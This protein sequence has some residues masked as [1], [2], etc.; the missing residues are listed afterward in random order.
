MN[1]PLQ[2]GTMLGNSCGASSH[3]PPS[4]A[5]RGFTRRRTCWKRADLPC[6]LL[7]CWWRHPASPANKEKN[8]SS[9]F[10]LV[11]FQIRSN[12]CVLSRFALFSFFRWS[13]SSRF[14][15]LFE[16][17]SSSSLLPVVARPRGND[18]A[19]AAGGL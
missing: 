1:A 6:F 10:Y 7:L 18:R 5:A 13:V 2:A 4:L 16:A 3:A 19:A 14:W 11:I 8:T 17:S 9:R 15:D 12:P